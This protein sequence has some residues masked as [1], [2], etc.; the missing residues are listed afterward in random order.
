MNEM[1]ESGVC[2]IGYCLNY[3]VLA[4]VKMC[5]EGQELKL[6]IL[7]TTAYKLGC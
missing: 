1:E 5:L 4:I 6:G 2:L 3:K 7:R